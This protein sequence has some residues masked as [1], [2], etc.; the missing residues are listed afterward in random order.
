[1]SPYVWVR[2][3]GGDKQALELAPVDANGDFEWVTPPRLVVR[4]EAFANE[5]R[6][7]A[8][9]FPDTTTAKD[10]LAVHPRTPI[11]ASASG[12]VVARVALHRV[13]AFAEA[14]GAV[15]IVA[16]T[17]LGVVV[18]FTDSSELRPWEATPKAEPG[19]GSGMGRLSGPKVSCPFGAPLY[20]LA[21]EKL[22]HV[23]RLRDGS[24]PEGPKV[25]WRTLGKVGVVLDGG[26]GAVRAGERYAILREDFRITNDL[27]HQGV[28][29]SF[30]VPVGEGACSQIA[31]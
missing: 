15:R 17:P 9:P 28:V 5:K 1:L 4:C 31:R 7:S 16:D 19:G 24:D 3:V 18:G 12:P 11:R 6:W 8:D 10:A 22:Y 21:K 20:V 25:D 2:A 27:W 29:G 23:G 26:P 13:A 30:V 14:S